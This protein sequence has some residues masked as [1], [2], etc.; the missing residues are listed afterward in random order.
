MS[1][2]FISLQQAID[3]T[4]RY[5]Q[6]KG[7]VVDPAFPGADILSICDTINKDALAA[8]LAKPE[9]AAIRLYYGMNEDLTIRPILV[10]VN[11]NNEDILPA[12]GVDAATVGED[13]VDDALRCPTYCPPPSPLNS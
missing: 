4:T 11:K 10:A 5:R 1:T 2:G 12:I 9:C 6:N 13:I 7:S 8:L 3:M